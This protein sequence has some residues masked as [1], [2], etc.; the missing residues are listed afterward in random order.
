[1]LR[2]NK[3]RTI[4]FKI[5]FLSFI[6]C[7]L[8]FIFAS[9]FSFAQ[10]GSSDAIAIRVIPNPNHYSAL[11]WYQKQN[12]KGSPQAIAVDGYEAIRDGRTVYVNVAN[13][14]GNVLYT[15]IYLISYNQ[16]A[17]DV[18]HDIFSQILSHWKFNS[19]LTAVGHCRNDTLKTCLEDE[20][21]PLGDFCDS[22]K[23]RA[24]RDVRRLADLSDLKAVLD[25]YYKSK[26]GYPV[27]GAGTYLPNKTM[28]VWPSW[29]DTL[30]KQLSVNL[31]IDPI[32][33]LNSEECP[34][35]NE[36]TC[37]NEVLKRFY[38][39][40]PVF[41]DDSLTYYYTVN[42]LG[43]VANFCA[44]FESGYPINP[45]PVYCMDVCLDF[46][47]DG[48]GAPGSAACSNGAGP[49]CNDNDPL[50]NVSLVAENS[51]LAC[52]NGI[53][54]DCDG[55]VDCDDQNCAG[56]GICAISP[57]CDF[58][59]I[60]EGAIGESA[61]SCTDCSY[62][63]GDFICFD[64]CEC[65]GCT[66]YSFT[67]CGCGNGIEN[68]GEEC[69][70]GGLVDGDGC[71][72]ECE[73]EIFPC[74]DNDGDRYIS[75]GTNVALCGN[76]CGLFSNLSC[77]GNTDCDDNNA[78]RYPTNTEQCDSI[79]QDCDGNPVNGFTDETCVWLCGNNGF[80]WVGLGSPFN[81]CGNDAD[82]DEYS[83]ETTC[84]DNFDNDCDGDIDMADSDCSGTCA[85]NSERDWVVA[86]EADCNQCDYNGDNDGD[87]E[88][89]GG[90]FWLTVYPAQP[91]LADM[92]DPDCIPDG[93]AINAASPAVHISKYE[94][95]E[96]TCNDNIDN[97]CDGNMDCADAN[98]L[99]N[100][101]CCA[102]ECSSGETGCTGNDSW[103]CGEAGDGD[104]C[105][106]P[107]T[108]ACPAQFACS[109][110]THLCE[111]VCTDIDGD[112]FNVEGGLCFA[113]D[114]DDAKGFVFPGAQETCDTFDND[115]DT[116]T[117][118]GCDDDI[119]KY[120][121]ASMV[122]YGGNSMCINT[123]FSADGMSGNDCDDTALSANPGVPS[124]IS[125]T[126][127]SDG[128]DNDCDS[129][130][131]CSDSDC[132]ADPACIVTGFCTFPLIFPCEFQ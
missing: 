57:S 103:S 32:N 121:D 77:F 9:K 106:E 97:D 72:S 93:A 54:D 14:S 67:D 55:L 100:P 3:K 12:F 111:L 126:T 124:E 52:G 84:G 79:D 92:C 13:V 90:P 99:G 62:A 19:N 118:E 64:S 78:S 89:V 48:Y 30:A 75:E 20:E 10:T 33:K 68:T 119:D 29:K 113:I 5:N 44:S 16:E 125:G 74:T 56:I 71:S 1:M 11:R 109:A 27:L 108:Q 15:N 127:C 60:C 102:D 37:W 123:V 107:V 43:T 120:C 53:D 73:S 49:D 76:V 31:P 70:D 112:G 58:D 23:A 94:A 132:T 83:T 24:V 128:F 130:T 66:S 96:A 59:C 26:G 131:D 7:L 46:D 87:Q 61:G 105:L 21:C 34:G 8:F 42:D 88:N 80:D 95:A 38:T 82:E 104:T 35:Y 81:C 6:F 86:G 36:T 63:N 41:P 40:L 115:C 91:T 50:I 101:A 39:D 17:E 28:S 69:D 117:D 110:T 122:L 45:P 85:N 2:I 114:C 4:F 22:H 65:L 116:L 129:D 47:D 51:P 25:N 98:C 18:T